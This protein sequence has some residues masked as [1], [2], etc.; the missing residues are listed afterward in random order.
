MA[1][2]HDQPVDPGAR[3]VVTAA[4][5]VLALLTVAGMV[6][7]RPGDPRG[8]PDLGELSSFDFVDAKVVDVDPAG[9]VNSPPEA[10]IECDLVHVEV[11]GGPDEGDVTSL[12]FPASAMTP[13]LDEGDRIVLSYSPGAEPGFQYNLADRGRKPVLLWLAVLFAVSVV[14]LGRLRGVT[15][16]AGL[17]ATVIV[18]VAFALPAIIDG[19]SPIA[20]SVVAAAAISFVALYAAHGFT[21][22]TTVAL[23]GT[24]AS[25]V[26][27]AVLAVAFVEVAQFSGFGSEEATFLSSVTGRIDLR[28]LLLAGVVVGALGAIDDMTVTQASAVWELRA[29]DPA[30]S[31]RRIYGAGLRIGRDH[32]ASTVNT[33]FLAYAGASM[34]LFVLFV[35]AEQSLASIAN[36]EVVAVEIVRTLVGSIGLVAAVPLT[37]WL[38]ARCLPPAVDAAEPA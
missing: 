30:M 3:R 21:V 10:G 28:G 2:R 38:A 34:P 18:L 5:V 27:T 23:L 29:A 20:V 16:L 19:R 36:S 14:V 22:M 9:C 26:I 6:V 8:R 25:L 4:A 11:L 12:E 7:L 31:A 13:D 15:A 32:V 1:H 35:L 33:L 24:L 17:V 37:T